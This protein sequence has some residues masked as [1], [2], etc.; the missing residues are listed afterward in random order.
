MP[1][2]EVIAISPKT[3]RICR[4]GAFILERTGPGTETVSRTRS[5]L[6]SVVKPLPPL[7]EVASLLGEVDP[8]T[9]EEADAVAKAKPIVTPLS[10]FRS[11]S[12]RRNR[13]WVLAKYREKC[14]LTPRKPPLTLGERYTGATVT[15]PAPEKA[16]Y[17]KRPR[18]RL[19]YQRPYD[20]ARP[21]NPSKRNKQSRSVR[22]PNC[23]TARQRSWDSGPEMASRSKS[24][25]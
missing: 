5:L 18:Q 23:I 14:P 2:Q 17:R 11:A 16:T 20:A 3:S 19:E 4:V 6:T 25:F 21:K 1:V 13:E 12:Y 10:P 8:G 24:S 22:F 7:E 15:N 9:F